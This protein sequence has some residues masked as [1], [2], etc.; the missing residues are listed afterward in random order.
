MKKKKLQR[1]FT[2]IELM[3]SLVI[4]GALVTLAVPNFNK[5]QEKTKET[6]IMGLVKSL[7]VSVES[8]A[9]VNGRFPRGV[10]EPL[11]TFLSRLNKDDVYMAVPKNPFTGK[12]YG[13]ND[14]SGKITY[15]FDK[16]SSTYT[17]RGFGQGNLSEVMVLSNGSF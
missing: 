4:I 14:E 13:V 9:M 10:S 1:G 7:Q 12:L 3:I 11:S 6:S 16:D 17:I 8:Y 5:I 15:T 2:L